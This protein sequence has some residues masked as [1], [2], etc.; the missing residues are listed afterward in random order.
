MERGPRQYLKENPLLPQFALNR[1]P[2]TST[3]TTTT[4][5]TTTKTR[6]TT[7]TIKVAADRLCGKGSH[8]GGSNSSSHLVFHPRTL[9][10]IKESKNTTGRC[11][12]HL[13][14]L[15][16]QENGLMKSVEPSGFNPMRWGAVPKPGLAAQITPINRNKPPLLSSRLPRFLGI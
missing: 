16:Q 8:G 12:L 15:I 3:T 10:G 5:K 2:C 9:T 4:T 7:T 1:R 11:T 14:Y 6:T 13:I